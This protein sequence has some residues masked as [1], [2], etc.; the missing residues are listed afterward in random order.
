M[1]ELRPFHEYDANV[2]KLINVDDFGPR[3]LSPLVDTTAAN[4]PLE[5]LSNSVS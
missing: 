5:E 1:S 2:M 3:E 4:M